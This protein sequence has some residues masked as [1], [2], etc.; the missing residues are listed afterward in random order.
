M[1]EQ[2]AFWDRLADKY[3]A[4][5]IADEEAYRIKLARTQAH[6]TP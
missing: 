5:P 2:H 6:F 4:Q 1:A 3:A